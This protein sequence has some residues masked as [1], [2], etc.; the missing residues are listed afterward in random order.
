LAELRDCLQECHHQDWGGENP[1]KSEK[2][3]RK[4]DNRSNNSGNHP[5]N[6]S[7]SSNNRNNSGNTNNNS[8]NRKREDRSPPSN[9]GKP[10]K[11]P[12]IKDKLGKDGKL[13]LEEHKCRLDL[14]L[15]LFCG[16][17]G[18]LA[19]NCLKSLKAK[20]RSVKADTTPKDKTKS[21]ESKNG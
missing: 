15:C 13:T 18:H 8:S 7:S 11:K 17:I 21:D 2:P 12:D 9:S 4:L 20:A 14:N 16:G 10:Y 6:Q 1:T 5:G 19:K 3:E